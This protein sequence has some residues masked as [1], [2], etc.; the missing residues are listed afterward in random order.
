MVAVHQSM[1]SAQSAAYPFR[2]LVDS[3]LPVTADIAALVRSSLRDGV[4]DE[5]CELAGVNLEHLRIAVAG[6]PHDRV[7][8]GAGPEGFGDEPRAQ[9]MSTQ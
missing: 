8:A 2:V 6:L 1:N 7:G 9:G 5:G 3:A 4:A